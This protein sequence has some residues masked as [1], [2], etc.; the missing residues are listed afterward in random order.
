[1][2]RAVTSHGAAPVDPRRRASR[3]GLIEILRA[4]GPVTRAELAQRG[5]LSRA[6]VSSVIGELLAEGLVVEDEAPADALRV[7]QGRPPSLVRL[8]R[9]AGV[10]LGID[11]GKRHLRIAL[12]D[13]GHQVLSERAVPLAGDHNADQG[14]D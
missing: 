12:A 13:L 4:L 5:G 8:N 10:A 1:M 9:G 2:I 3:D 7:V 11:F 14:I 6:T